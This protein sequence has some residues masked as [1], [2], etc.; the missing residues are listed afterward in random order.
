MFHGFSNTKQST[1]GRLCRALSPE[2]I[3]AG[4]YKPVLLAE[5]KLWTIIMWQTMTWAAQKN[6]LTKKK[7]LPYLWM[8][9]VIL[10]LNAEQ[11]IVFE[12]ESKSLSILVWN[13]LI[14]RI[15]AGVFTFANFTPAGC[16]NS[17]ISDW[18]SKVV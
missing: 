18:W 10:T 2:H 12:K 9:L 13:V 15:F 17:E 11:N 14:N 3:T 4:L 6:F 16:R 7:W 5:V 8:L 1:T